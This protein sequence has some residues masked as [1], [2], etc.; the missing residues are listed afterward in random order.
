MRQDG[1][2]WGE[3]GWIEVDCGGS[4]WNQWGGYY[5]GGEEGRRGSKGGVNECSV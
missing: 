4:C 1:T 3:L 2:G 5:T